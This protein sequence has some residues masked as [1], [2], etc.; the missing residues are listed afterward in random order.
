LD[1]SCLCY[2]RDPKLITR[3]RR[4]GVA[5]HELLGDLFCEAALDSPAYIYPCQFL[6][7]RRTLR[8]ELTSLNRKIGFF[9]VSLRAHRHVFTG[10]HRHCASDE[11]RDTGD[12][13][14]YARG[15]AT[16]NAEYEACG[17]DDAIIGAENRSAEPADAF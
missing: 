7:L 8:L 5:R 1:G 10:S 2:R 6:P 13:N 12:D 17:R 14:A 11:T 3:V 16:R 4:Y 15:P 9:R